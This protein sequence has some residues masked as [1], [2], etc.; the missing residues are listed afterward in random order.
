MSQHPVLSQFSYFLHRLAQKY[1]L[2]GVT[3]LGR[4]TSELLTIPS[5]PWP[6]NFQVAHTILEGVFPFR[7]QL[8]PL[9]DCLDYLGRPDRCP[10]PLLPRLHGFEW[11]K[12][13]RAI[14]TNPSR[15]RAR[16]LIMHWINQNHSW[17]TKSWLSPA[18]RP[19][20]TAN[21]LSSWI[22]VYDF[23]GASADDFFKQAF[24]RSLMKQYRY[25]RRIY[26][27]ITDPLQ[28]F[29][30]L[31]SLIACACTLPRQKGRIPSFVNSLQK[32]LKAQILADGGHVSR[33]P[34]LQLIILR[35]LI[36]IRSLLKNIEAE[37]PPFLQ[38]AINVMAPM[39]RL[40]RHGDGGLADFAGNI[41]PCSLSFD[42]E[43]IS[44]AVVDMALSL[45]DVRGRPPGRA[46][47]MG[48]ERC[49]GKSGLILLNV[50]PSYN[51]VP[52]LTTE[53]EP[54]VNILDF[55]WSVGRQRILRRSDLIVQLSDHSWL[56]IDNDQ[57]SL[58]LKRHS[59]DG[60][61][62]LSADFDQFIRGVSYRHQRQLYLGGEEGDFRGHDIFTLSQPA[63][64]AV[65]F[66]FSRNVEVLSQTTKKI[67]IKVYPSAAIAGKGESKK[68]VQTWSFI[69]KGASD[70]LWQHCKETGLP[71][72]MLLTP[73]AKEE[74]Q[75][76]K[77]AFR[78]DEN[79][80]KR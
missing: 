60:N 38:Q 32:V 74:P 63:M 48:Y 53:G 34:A 67:K 35:D 42:P 65:R 30:V 12:D 16:Q 40:F 4:S 66:I 31:K 39:V 28:A 44:P 49:I 57:G 26:T 52:L 51:E 11:L 37:D 3:L 68:T 8:I 6:G 55:E 33:S 46:P 20:I 17:S 15:K 5:D 22:S 36:D 21:R 69:T 59:K 62:Y 1:R 43:N 71:Y 79:I 24:F 50:K 76:I 75:T 78:L 45:A 73:L 64:A 25:L 23:F 56:K 13:L 9:K 41:D 27:S 80:E 14:S 47:Y 72:L 29:I 61:G 10:S 58:A 54:G 7:G 2:Y 70:V 77:W 19:E 18:W